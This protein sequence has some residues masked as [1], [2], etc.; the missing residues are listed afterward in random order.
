MPSITPSHSAF[1]SFVFPASTTDALH[2]RCHAVGEPPTCAQQPLVSRPDVR[3]QLAPRRLPAEGALELG[4]AGAGQR[5]G[6][7]M[8]GLHV[9]AQLLVARGGGAAERA[10]RL[11]VRVGAIHVTPRR[12]FR[13]QHLSADAAHRHGSPTVLSEAPSPSRGGGGYA[14]PSPPRGACWERR[15]PPVGSAARGG[16]HLALRLGAQRR[17]PRKVQRCG[18][19][20]PRGRRA[21][22]VPAAMGKSRSVGGGRVRMRSGRRAPCCAAGL[23]PAWGRWAVAGRC[24]ARCWD[25]PAAPGRSLSVRDCLPPAAGK[26]ASPSSFQGAQA[27]SVVS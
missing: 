8:G 13:G 22:C 18:V 16:R 11:P 26:S 19:L 2:Q 1:L 14:R 25:C 12:R 7:W 24:R 17:V 3:L 21:R 15:G 4:A 20:S 5:L 10:A 27:R 6:L 23:L 9:L